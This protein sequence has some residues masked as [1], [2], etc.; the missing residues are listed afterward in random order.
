MDL[1]HEDLANDGCEMKG[2]IW[3]RGDLRLL[4]VG[5]VFTLAWG[6]IGYRLFDLQGTQAL[7]NAEYGFNQRIKERS[8]DPPR[9]TIFDRDG[10]EMAMTIDGYDVVVDPML[11][12]D[13]DAAAVVLAPF[14]EKSYEELSQEL[15][16]GQ[17]EGRR[18]VEIVMR[19]DST[20]R[21][22]I[23]RAVDAANAVE[24]E[25]AGR[26]AALTRV[27]YRDRPLRV[28]PAGS[29]AA[30]VIGLVRSDDNSGI[31]GLEKTFDSELEGRPG[32]IVVEV[33]PRGTAIPQGEV[34]V[35]PSIAGSDIVSTIDREIQFVAE[36]ALRRA[37]QKTNA[38]SGSV[39]VLL[40]RTGEVVAMASW[41]GLDLNDRSEVTA[42]VLRNRAVADVYE[43][44]STLKTVTVA[45]ALDQGI[46]TAETPIDTPSTVTVGEFEYADHG[47][48]PPWLPVQDVFSRS[49]NVGTIEIQNRLG[50]D[51]HYEY[52]TAFGLGSPSGL[53]ISGER[54]GSLD[55]AVSWN[56][57]SGSSIAIGY[58]V[59]TTALQMAA[60]YATIANDGVWTEPYLVKEIIKANGSRIATK[61]RSRRVVSEE[62]AAEMRRLLGR[63]V[64]TDNGTGRRARMTDYTSGGKT[65]TSQ[66]F[67]VEAG[68]YSDDTTASFIGIAPLTDP[69]VVVAIVLDAP[70]GS[71][72]DGTELSLGG[73]SAAPVFADVAQTALHQLGVAPD[74]D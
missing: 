57:T 64:E 9:G 55:P 42:D 73:A 49:S 51:L 52:L 2:Q 67:D 43:P 7:A 70:Q 33:D 50:N 56:K 71:L 13:P 74:R 68:V 25:N 35:E 24:V 44:G 39:V 38:E 53:D 21:K 58:A 19:V 20:R 6:G 27:F 14:S 36:Q 23:E 47:Y 4:V 1:I 31:E 61:P 37:I 16:E 63:V 46:V 65:G 26:K 69:R 11:L 45:A 59:G 40:P 17:A 32:K 18:Y 28:Y 62:T 8:I 15:M 66:K 41:P 48:N 10:V 3:K 30:Q 60:V 54:H 72:E 12:D 29:V 5:L 34:L 22:E